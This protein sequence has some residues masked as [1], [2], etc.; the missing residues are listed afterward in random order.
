MWLEILSLLLG[1]GYGYINPGKEDRIKLL[2]KGLLIGL[3]LGIIFG[4]IGS[5]FGGLLFLPV[6][7]ILW[8][9]AIGWLAIL[10]V[11]GTYVGD[12]LEVKFKKS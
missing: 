6:S 9:I 2:K 11:V 3:I 5:F 7:L 1:V 10:F 12:W 8:I 4:I